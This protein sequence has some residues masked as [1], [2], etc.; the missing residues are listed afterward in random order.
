MEERRKKPTLE[1]L[2]TIHYFDIPTI[3]TLAELGTRTVY[4]ALLR[5]PIYQRDAEKIVAALAQHVGLELTLEHVDIV[6]WEEYQVLWIIRASANTHE[7]LTDAYNFVYA[8]NQEHARDLA[9]KWLEQLAHLPHH[10][11]TPCPEGLHIGCISIPGYIQSQAYC[12][13]VE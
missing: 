13:S 9:R 5:K 6:V 8:R 7:E 4:H 10:Y 12:V 3:A 1:Q 11:Y 2:R